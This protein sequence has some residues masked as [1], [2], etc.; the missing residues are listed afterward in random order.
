VDG[1]NNVYVPCWLIVNSVAKLT[2]GTGAINTF[3][4]YSA[5]PT[6]STVAAAEGVPLSVNPGTWPGSPSFTYQWKRSLIDGYGGSSLAITFPGVLGWMGIPGATSSSYTPV[7]N[8]AGWN[9]RCQ[10]KAGTQF[11]YSNYSKLVTTA[12][13]AYDQFQG[14]LVGHTFQ[15]GQDLTARSMNLGAGWTAGEGVIQTAYN[16]SSYGNGFAKVI[17]VVA[18][19][20]VGDNAALYVTD[21]GIADADVR[22][23][24][25]FNGTGLAKNMGLVAR[26]TNLNNYWL[27]WA[28]ATTNQV[29][30]YEVASGV[31]TTRGTAAFTWADNTN[32]DLRI[33]MK[34]TVADVY[35]NG[36]QKIHYTS[37]TSNQSATKHGIRGELAGQIFDSFAVY[38][39]P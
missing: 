31:L 13:V 7:I 25:N 18:D 15:F 32:Y 29:V 1:S 23:I 35:V 21:S 12:A 22:V 27:A 5:P 8:D 30:L 3:S 36:V 20:V 19:G 9:I 39:A 16:G 33:N 6:L 24:V 28:Q 34:G 11:A 14:V 37:A 26:Y 2:A 17:T 38:N 10:V 4:P